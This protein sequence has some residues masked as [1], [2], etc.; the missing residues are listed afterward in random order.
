MFNQVN[1]N[2]VPNPPNRTPRWLSRVYYP[3][4]S[5]EV[6]PPGLLHA[7][8]HLSILVGIPNAAP[9]DRF[10]GRWSWG[11][12]QGN[13][14]T[15]PHNLQHFPCLDTFASAHSKIYL[16]L[17]IHLTYINPC[18]LAYTKAT[19]NKIQISRVNPPPRS[20]IT[21]VIITPSSRNP[22]IDVHLSSD[23]LSQA[24]Q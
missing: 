9:W 16:L 3:P 17:Q 18:S 8:I 24:S 13:Y 19:N 15:L 4:A 22:S 5:H 6:S 2:W 12:K 21:T 20:Y 7:R 11:A 23:R 1:Y 14:N 10:R